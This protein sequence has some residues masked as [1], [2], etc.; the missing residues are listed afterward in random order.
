MVDVDSDV[1]HRTVPYRTFELGPPQ[2]VSLVNRA[3]YPVETYPYGQW[4]YQAFQ[5]E[6]QSRS[7]ATLEKDPE[8]TIKLFYSTL[9]GGA[10]GYRNPSFLATVR[11][12]GG[13]FGPAIQAPPTE[14]KDTLL[15]DRPK[16][17]KKLVSTL[18]ENGVIGPNAYYLNHETN[19][20]YAKGS[21]NGGKLDVPA[22]FIEAKWDQTCDSAM[23]RLAE[24]M[25]AMCSRLT[26]C[27]IEADHF[28]ALEKA[29][30]TTAAVA[31]WL[32]KDLGTG[33]RLL[34]LA[35]IT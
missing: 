4:D 2:M 34:C 35:E 10:Q 8:N 3:I 19:A 25:R 23:S 17:Y 13:W 22:L 15:H 21:V 14:L 5:L 30:E 20:E 28:V 12:Q 24:P 29:A 6:H 16:I 33:R 31:R 27:S 7:I 11:A 1:P 32:V 26:E 9:I 18:R